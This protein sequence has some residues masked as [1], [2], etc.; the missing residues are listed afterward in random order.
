MKKKCQQKTPNHDVSQ[1]L[2]AMLKKYNIDKTKYIKPYKKELFYDPKKLIKGTKNIENLICP[3]CYNILKNPISCNSTEK[4][5]S[6][7]EECINES[8]KRN[9]KCPLCKQKFEYKKNKKFDKLLHKLKF[10][11]IYSEDGCQDILDYSMY[12]SHIENCGFREILYECQIEKYSESE[13]KFEKC[14]YVGS[15]KRINRHF[16]KC[17]F[18]KSI[19]F[20]CNQKIIDALFARHMESRCKILYISKDAKIFIGK[21]EDKFQE[22]KGYGKYFFK[23]GRICVGEC[24]NHVAN[25]FGIFKYKS[26]VSFEGEMKNGFSEG[27]GIMYDG[28]GEIK[29]KGEF[30]KGHPNGIGTYYPEKGYRYEG[31]MKDGDREGYG[32]LYYELENEP[33]DRYEGEFKDD[34]IDGYGI[35]YYKDGS[36]YNGEFEECAE[37]FGLRDL[38]DYYYKGQFKNGYEWGYGTLYHKQEKYAYK[39]EFIEGFKEGYGILYYPDGD[40]FEGEF[41]NDNHNGFGLL[42]KTNGDKFINIWEDDKLIFEQKL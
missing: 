2:N 17:A 29:F 8:L 36:I 25:G 34:I 27:Y 42:Y 41:K 10:E 1:D 33:I 12:L 20:Y 14:G 31:Q 5:H 30:Q 4:S 15:I 38:K 9:N 3:I 13:L 16:L 6:F 18:Q 40:I 37:G 21:H 19:C 7:C 24:Y 32:I 28:T 23:D 11:C 22:P 39:G 26:V 35:M